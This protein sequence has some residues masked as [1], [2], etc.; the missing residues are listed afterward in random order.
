VLLTQTVHACDLNCALSGGLR[1]WRQPRTIHDPAKVVLDLAAA[2]ALGGDCA[3]DIAM[4]RA[5]PGVF[6]SVASDP[7]VA[8]VI[9]DI[10]CLVASEP[11]A[12]RSGS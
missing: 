11:V 8:R 12:C 2:V 7:T 5:Q 3:A 1:P 4:L 10:V 9:S 6:G